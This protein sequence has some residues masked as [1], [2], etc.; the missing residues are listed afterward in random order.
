MD[1]NHGPELTTLMTLVYLMSW[2]SDWMKGISH[3]IGLS[4]ASIYTSR[5]GMPDG[6]LEQNTLCQND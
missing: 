4:S 6:Y 1:P 3:R 2:G 5:V